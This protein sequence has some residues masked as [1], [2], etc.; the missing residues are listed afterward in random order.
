MDK[1]TAQLN[2]MKRLAESRGSKVQAVKLVM[3]TLG[4][5]LKDAKFYID[6]GISGDNFD[7]AHVIEKFERDL[8]FLRRKA[9]ENVT[10]DD[11]V[12]TATDARD[13]WH[14]FFDTEQ[15][16]IRAFLGRFLG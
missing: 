10:F 8:E 6:D 1:Y 13:T 15:D 16:A 5:G 9:I 2:Q 3:D 11:V 7:W 12:R 14:L 4:M